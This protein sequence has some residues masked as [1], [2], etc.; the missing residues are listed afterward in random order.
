MQVEVGP[1]SS[2]SAVAFADFA[3][4]V[5]SERGPDLPVDVRE[6][7]VSYLA[8]WRSE[9]AAGPTLVWRTEVP[10]EVA[11]YLVLAFYRLAQ[12]VDADRPGPDPLV[13]VDATAFYQALVKG[14]LG[15]MAE[16]GPGTAEFSDHL[17]SF[18]PGQPDS[19]P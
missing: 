3:E 10:V 11:E 16:S 8:T 6:A 14:L 9:A 1:V 4:G 5:L 17:R 13:P 12:Q 15:A 19:D 2:A 7:F 18:W